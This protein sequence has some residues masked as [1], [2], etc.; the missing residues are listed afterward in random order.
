MDTVLSSV[1]E[2]YTPPCRSCSWFSE[3]LVFSKVVPICTWMD[4]EQKPVDP[5]E[6][7]DEDT[8]RCLAYYSHVY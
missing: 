8:T 2:D 4:A 5:I 3:M 6:D 7:P 1:S